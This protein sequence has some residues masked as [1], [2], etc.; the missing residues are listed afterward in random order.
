MG[1]Q[2]QEKGQGDRS[3]P[4]P[5]GASDRKTTGRGLGRDSLSQELY[6][7]SLS[8]QQFPGKN[9]GLSHSY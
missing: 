5:A 1:K 4:S 3:S 8:D 7:S 9:A 6:Q 2:P